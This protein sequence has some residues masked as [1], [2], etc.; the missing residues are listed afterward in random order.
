M[1]LTTDQLAARWGIKPSTVRGYRYRGTGPEYYTIPRLGRPLGSSG[2][3]YPLDS[4]L[5]FEKANHI[6]PLNP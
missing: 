2:V 4:I 5:A 6:T 1:D 3:L